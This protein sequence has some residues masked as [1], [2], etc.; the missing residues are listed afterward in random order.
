MKQVKIALVGMGRIGKIH[1]R[2]INQ[3]FPNATIVAVADPQYD[4][5]AFKKEFG[6]VFFTEKAEEAIALPDVD[7]VLICTPTSS[8]ADLLEQ[9]AHCGKHIFCE[10]PMDLSL[11]R[12][13]ALNNL[14]KQMNVKLM[15]G[16]N[17]RFDPDF[18]QARQYVKDGKI[19]ALQIVKIT[20]RDPGLPPIDYLK[21]SGGL[22]MDMAIHDFDMA[23]YIM[24]KKVVEVFAKGLVLIDEAVATADDVDTALTTLTFE[25]G[26]YAVIDNSRKAVYGYDQRLEIFGNGGMI[27]VENNLHNRNVIYD[28][29]GIHSALPLDF[30]MDRYSRSYVKE[31]E[32][33]IDALVNN[34]P[35]PVSGEDGLEATRI[36]VAAKMSMVEERPV[37]LSE[38]TTKVKELVA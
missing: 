11:E 15:L 8:H 2:N 35:M 38:I 19:G 18:M 13:A 37:K 6:D 10:K 32:L 9:A 1:F 29:K 12:T 16:F 33:F 30:F 24:N 22:F 17:R 21:N 23:R 28:E 34:T 14:V 3:L 27:K 7:A 31:M 25:D 4:E 26:T 5:Q 20:S 36:A